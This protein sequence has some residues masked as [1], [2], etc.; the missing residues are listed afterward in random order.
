M[1]SALTVSGQ[2]ITKTFTFDHYTLKQVGDYNEIK[3]NNTKSMAAPGNPMQPYFLSNILLPQ[4]AVVRSVEITPQAVQSFLLDFPLMPMQHVR[5]LSYEGTSTFIQNEKAYQKELNVAFENSLTFKQET[6]NGYEIAQVKFSPVQ[7]FPLKQKVELA[8]EVTITIAYEMSGEIKTKMISN[9]NIVHSTIQDLV[10][11]PEALKTYPASQKKSQVIDAIIITPAEFISDFEP[12][13]FDYQKR[14]LSVETISVESIAI[15]YTGADLQ[16]KIRNTIIDLYQNNDVRYVLLGGDVEHIPYRGFYCEV[17]SSTLMTDDDIPADLYYMALD[18]NWNTD[19]DDKWGEPDEDDLLPEVALSRMPFSTHEDLQNMLAKTLGYTNH[20]VEGE[21][22]NPLLAGEHLY[23]APLTWGA[24]YL[25]LIHGTHDDNGYTTT[26]IPNDHPYD[27]LYDRNSQWT[28]TGLINEINS[29]HP[30][31]HHV[32][33]S[34]ATY[35]MRLYNSDITTS[36]FS[37]VDGTTHNFPIIYT[38]GCICGSFD[39]N[40]CIAEEML[41]LDRFAAAFVGNSRYGWFNEGQTEGPSQHLHREFVDALY[42]DKVNFLA[43]AHLISKIESSGWVEAANQHEP[44]AIRWVFYDCNALGDP[45]LP[46]WTDELRTVD[47]SVPDGILI[48]ETAVTVNAMIGS[49][50]EE[51]IYISLAQNGNICGYG[52]TDASGM[53]DITLI[54]PFT[55]T[56]DIE[57]IYSGYNIVKDTVFE[58]LTR[59]DEP[60][61]IVSSVELGADAQPVYGHNYNVGLTIENVGT[62]DS[63]ITH[64]EVSTTSEYASVTNGAFDISPV[65]ALQSDQFLSTFNLAVSDV[66]PDQEPIAINFDFYASDTVHHTIQK[67]LVIMA[68]KLSW[69][70]IQISDAAGG[71]NNGV[72]ELGEIV[73]VK[74]E[75]NNTGSMNPQ[76]IKSYIADFTENIEVLSDTVIINPDSEAL[77][78]VQ[79]VLHALPEAANNSPVNISIAGQYDAYTMSDMDYGVTLGMAIEDFETGDFS[80]YPWSNDAIY[81]WTISQNDVSAGLYSG[82]S[83]IIDHDQSSALTITLDVEEDNAISFDYKVSCE[84][85]DYSLWDYL[86][87]SI[88]GTVLSEWDGIIPWSNASYNVTA[89]THIFKWEYIK[90]GSVSEG[91]DCAWVD[92]IILPIN[93]YEP[94][95]GNH[96]PEITSENTITTQTGS[97]FSHLIS[98]TDNDSD[99]LQANLIL[100]PE[101]VQLSDSDGDTWLMEGAV[102]AALEK[103][104]EILVSVT[105]GFVF[106]GQSIILDIDGVGV[107]DLNTDNTIVTVYPQPANDQLFIQLKEP[108]KASRIQLFDASGRM[109]QLLHLNKHSNS[110]IELNVND[111]NVGMYLIQIYTTDNE[112]ITKK[113]VVK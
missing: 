67:T 92:N 99:P 50:P 29:G 38:H 103:V 27:T 25:D 5:P 106:S 90:D 20:P 70:Q 1:I 22:N 13:I 44:G 113:I 111:L 109:I 58:T 51:N 74:A 69:G 86:A 33:H 24:Q 26:G 3:I 89:G 12:L 101:W 83:G 37:Q 36:N 64:I 95:V 43:E 98:A 57:I 93:G 53:V 96:T 15:E 9:R 28:A 23:D 82:R 55:N 104:P 6:L 110:E 14:A 94:P 63:E 100:A 107:S 46:I 30:F 62:V 66:A 80:K 18:G 47:I 59:P 91:E 16:E 78:E 34:N 21:L 48:G 85:S 19:G 45:T 49:N 8:R 61:L 10:D 35:A 42:N 54:E 4:G 77:F 39:S 97:A 112:I 2:K 56:D 84:D 41:Q 102:P 32:G 52:V 108:A 73:I 71:N 79:F 68:P 40:D 76:M 31:I 105:D 60:F 81:P 7:Y 17:E 65:A 87:F 11:N 75:I 72:L 88:D